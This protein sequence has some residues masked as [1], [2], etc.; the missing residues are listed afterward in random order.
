[1]LTSVS[2]HRS[3]ESTQLPAGPPQHGVALHGLLPAAAPQGLPN[4]AV[5]AGHP[6]ARRGTCETPVG[7]AGG[8]SSSSAGADAVVS[9]TC[10]FPA[11]HFLR[12]LSKR[13]LRQQGHR[14][15]AVAMK[16]IQPLS[17]SCVGS[18]PVVRPGQ[19]FW[20]L[21]WLWGQKQTLS[22]HLLTQDTSTCRSHVPFL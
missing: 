15:F 6:H 18:Q 16:C 11:A 22:P 14:G 17:P 21:M 9:C 5:I 10:C 7:S 20:S 3:A 1:M 4:G 19:H 2:F 8:V 13:A 12:F